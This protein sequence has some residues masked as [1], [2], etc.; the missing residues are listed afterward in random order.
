MKGFE[1]LDARE[2]VWPQI[3]EV[4]QGWSAEITEYTTE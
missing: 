4:L 2:R 3:E 1:R